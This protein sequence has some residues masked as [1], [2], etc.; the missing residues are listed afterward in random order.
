[1]RAQAIRLSLT[2]RIVVLVIRVLHRIHSLSQQVS[3][4][5]AT[6]SYLSP[7]LTAVIN[8]GGIPGGEEDELIEQVALVVN[9]ITYHC[10]DCGWHSS[11]VR[12][13][14]LQS[15]FQLETGNSP[16]RRQSPT[17]YRSLNGILPLVRMPHPRC[18]PSA[19]PFAWMP[20]KKKSR[21]LLMALR[22]KSRM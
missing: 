18:L 15:V 16:G 20:Q 2:D 17:F 13:K 9:I 22:H 6:F 5:G 12:F 7:L 8:S 4:D 21:L 10:G 11:S 14:G 1:M 3:F 19:R